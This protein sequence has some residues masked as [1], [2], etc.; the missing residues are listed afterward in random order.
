MSTPCLLR[1]V[2]MLCLHGRETGWSSFVIFSILFST[3][4][5]KPATPQEGN[6]GQ[7]TGATRG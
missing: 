3:P 2:S 5:G 6:L 4:S 7:N 1:G